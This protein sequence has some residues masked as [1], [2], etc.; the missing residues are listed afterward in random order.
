MK[1]AAVLNGTVSMNYWKY[2]G[3]DINST[4][5]L[6]VDVKELTTVGSVWVFVSKV[7]S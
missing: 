7:I 2:F 1:N 3:I 4:T 6:A 5:F